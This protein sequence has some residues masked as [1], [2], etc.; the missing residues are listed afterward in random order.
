MQTNSGLYCSFHRR[1]STP[2]PPPSFL[3]SWPI[4]RGLLSAGRQ[5][6]C[7]PRSNDGYLGGKTAIR[8]PATRERVVPESGG[9]GGVGGSR[10]NTWSLISLLPL[11]KWH[12]H[13]N[14]AYMWQSYKKMMQTEFYRFE[15]EDYLPFTI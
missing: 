7:I 3:T 13:T 10:T 9:G 12:K 8:V 1:P 4:G 15:K 6:I 2:P 14:S 11:S 5:I